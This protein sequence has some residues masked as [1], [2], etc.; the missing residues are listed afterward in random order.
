MKYGA[1]IHVPHR[2]NFNTF[3][4]VE[5]SRRGHGLIKKLIIPSCSLNR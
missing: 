1:D 4:G 2:M 3:S 5:M